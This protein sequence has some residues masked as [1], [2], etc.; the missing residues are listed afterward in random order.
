MQKDLKV[1]LLGMR[2][3]LAYAVLRALHAMKARVGLICDS[4]SSIRMSRY[5]RVLYV[6]R[7]IGSEPSS[8]IVRIIEEEHR[9]EPVDFVVASDVAGAILLNTIEAE[10][11]PPVFPV[12]ENSVLRLLNNKWSFHKL[13]IAVG[14]PAPDT[15]FCAS[16]D[17]LDIG[18]IADKLSYPVVVK[19]VDLFGGDGVI[20]AESPETILTGVKCNPRYRYGE[21]GLVVQRYVPGRDWGVSAFAID[22]HIETALT[23]ACGPNWRTEFREHPGLLDACGRI[24]EHVRYTGVVDFDCRMDEETNA[25]KLLECNPR[26]FHRVT[27]TRLCGVNFVKAG[28]GG[29]KQVLCGTSYFPIRDVLTLKGAKALLGG[30]WQFSALATDF[31]EILQDP[32]PAFVHNAGW[33]QPLARAMSPLFQRV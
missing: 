19:P 1:V 15:I 16:K 23:F 9:R 18:A 29:E 28:I 25:F 8:H 2:G 32:I 3:P 27:A 21:N 7:D 11:T 26:F 4:R 5:C 22:G 30:R 12:A 10:L 20:V 33:I 24:I 6:S 31:L 14:V 13:C 17:R